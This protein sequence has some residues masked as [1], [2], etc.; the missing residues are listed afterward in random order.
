VNEYLDAGPIILQRA[1]EVKNDDTAETLAA[2]ILEQEHGAYV[3]AVRGIVSS[4][5]AR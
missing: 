1:V 2:R 3:E 5:A 4:R